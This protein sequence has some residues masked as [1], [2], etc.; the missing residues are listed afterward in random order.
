MAQ[1]CVF[2][3]RS[4]VSFTQLRHHKCAPTRQLCVQPID[5]ESEAEKE[6]WIQILIKL[7]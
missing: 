3:D 5:I 4:F 7:V 6:N 2:C 1:Y